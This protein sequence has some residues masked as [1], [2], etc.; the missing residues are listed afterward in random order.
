MVGLAV[1]N[2]VGFLRSRGMK[3]LSISH[4]S[5][6]DWLG[7]PVRACVFCARLLS[8]GTCTEKEGLTGVGERVIDCTTYV[9]ET[10]KK[11]FN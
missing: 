7:L 9:C 10:V 5:H 6:S 4:P 1:Q 11:R 3:F 8:K 2:R